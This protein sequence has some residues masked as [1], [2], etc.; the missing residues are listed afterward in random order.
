MLQS[1]RTLALDYAYAALG[2]GPLPADLEVWFR[3]LHD[4]NP[5]VMYPLLVESAPKVEHLYLLRPDPQQPGVAVLE[6]R[7]HKPKAEPD[8]PFIKRPAQKPFFGAVLKRTYTQKKGPAPL[9]SR[10]NKTIKN[11][12][13]IRD[14][15]ASYSPLFGQFAQLASCSQVRKEGQDTIYTM[16]SEGCATVIDFAAQHLIKEQK[17][18]FLVLTDLAGRLPGTIPEYRHYIMEHEAQLRYTT[19]DVSY[20]PDGS[21]ALCGAAHVDVYAQGIKGAGINILNQDRASAFPGANKANAWKRFAICLPCCRL[22][23]IYKLYVAPTLKTSIAGSSAMVV[24]SVGHDLPHRQRF[25][26]RIKKDYDIL[27]HSRKTKGNGGVERTEKSFLDK[28][29]ANEQALAS[30]SIF[31]GNFGQDIGD[32]QAIARNVL[33]S[34]LS[35]LSQI[36]DQVLEWTHPCFPKLQS[37]SLQINLGMSCLKAHFSLVATEG[38]SHPDDSVSMCNFRR[39][40]LEAV[41]QGKR[42]LNIDRFENELHQAMRQHYT[43]NYSDDANFHSKEVWDKGKR[44]EGKAL[45]VTVCGWV[46]HVARLQHYLRHEKIGVLPMIENPYVPSIPELTQFVGPESGI[47]SSAKAFAFWIGVLQAK[48]MMLQKKAGRSTAIHWLQSLE[49]HPNHLPRL[50]TQQADKLLTYDQERRGDGILRWRS[51]RYPMEEISA[52]GIELGDQINLTIEQTNYFLL[53]GLGI[54]NRVNWKSEDKK[55]TQRPET[56]TT[57]QDEAAIQ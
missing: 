5:D 3:Q 49:L 23:T 9:P 28:L 46:K 11:W 44:P 37:Y 47:D 30:I 51:I 26:R 52:L 18:V 29:T 12:E 27:I 20:H 45:G 32:V 38:N 53:L 24:P 16:P 22:L 6:V 40:I 57:K 8:Y 36:N 2:S 17:T 19:Q 39:E 50:F 41:F 55:S 43:L 14:A 54:A 4:S 33:P 25:I 34:R 13:E 56:K 7:D 31:W 21:C 1:F 35:T 42:L 48:V 15:G 10:V